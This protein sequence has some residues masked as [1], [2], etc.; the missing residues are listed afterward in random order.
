MLTCPKEF[1]QNV[2][3]IFNLDFYPCSH[4]LPSCSLIIACCYLRYQS[5]TSAGHIRPAAQRHTFT[6]SLAAVFLI[7]CLLPAVHSRCCFCVRPP[8]P[9]D[10][11]P[12]FTESPPPSASSLSTTTNTR[13]RT[14]REVF[15]PP[16]LL[17][18]LLGEKCHEISLSSLS[19]KVFLTRLIITCH[20]PY[21][22]FA[23]LHSPVVPD[24][25][26]ASDKWCSLFFFCF[27]F[28]QRGTFLN[29]RQPR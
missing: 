12:V 8:P 6:V 5:F 1:N 13:V 26:A 28:T 7:I 23:L 4:S 15:S 25:H 11:S 22:T 29:C 3:G 21:K 16:P 27:F 24:W 17:L 14:Q 18:L 19:A 9:P 20:L 10:H 2:T